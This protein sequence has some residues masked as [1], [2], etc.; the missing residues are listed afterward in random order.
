MGMRPTKRGTLPAELKGEI[1][2]ISGDLDITRPYVLDMHEARNPR[3]HQSLGWGVY[4]AIY[5]DDQVKSCMQQRISAVVAANWDVLPGDDEDPRSVQAAADAKAMISKLK[6]DRVT[7]KMLLATLNGYAVAEFEF[8]E[9]D[10]RHDIIGIKVKHA[11]RFR[12]DKDM[13][14]RMLTRTNMRP[15]I[16]VPPEKFWVLTYG[17][18]NDDEP[19]GEGLAEWLYWPTLFKRNGVAFWNKFLDRFASPPIVAKGRATD[20]AELDKMM[21]MI[22]DLRSGGAVATSDRFSIELLQAARTTGDFKEMIAIMDAAIAK[23]ILSQT[24]TTDNGSSLAQGQVHANVKLDL[25]KADADELSDSFN[26][27]P[28]STW[29]AHNYGPDVAPPKLVRAVEEEADLKMMAETDKVLAESG[30]V[31]TPESFA[32]TYGDG[33]EKA[34]AK[35]ENPTGTEPD[36]VQLADKP[37]S[38]AAHD[39]KPLYVRRDL[40]N[41]KEVIA[42][43]KSQGFKSTLPGSEMHVTITYS[44]RPVNWFEMGGSLTGEASE[45]IVAPGGPRVV[46]VLGENAVVLIFSSSEL[47]WRHE[48]M[49]DSGASWDFDQ[50]LPHVTISYDGAPADLNAVS[51]YRGKLVFGPEIFEEINP[52]WNSGVSE[53]SFAE[54]TKRGDVLDSDV[55]AVMAR[56]DF[57]EIPAQLSARLLDA[58]SG[59]KSI[60]E[61]ET[62]LRDGMALMDDRALVDLLTKAKQAAAVRGLVGNA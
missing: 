9:A 38:L 1:A 52:D 44:K 48:R 56:D 13:K 5:K 40:L 3:L 11:R 21:R 24:M 45:L 39:P 57:L 28:L 16:L 50:Y 12:Y 60:D 4:A 27:G 42:W 6:W 36:K 8:G 30:W 31:R 59:A 49:T 23:I 18:D 32:D 53:R 22:R 15:G 62:T 37:A 41:H 58:L 2:S 19:Y 33:Y 34:E 46:S 14:L 51:P 43:A 54:H 55:D 17:S 29:C 7:S 25:V 47:E 26:D 35:K 20:Q 61:I 10:G